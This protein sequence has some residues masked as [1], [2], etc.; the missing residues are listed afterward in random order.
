MQTNPSDIKNLILDFGGVIYEI[1][2]QKQMETFAELGIRNFD[3]LYSQARQSPLFADLECGRLDH[4]KFRNEV[5]RFIGRNIS[6]AEIDKAWNSILVGFP[7]ENVRFLEKLGKRY[8]LFL[9]SNTNAIHYDIY[10]REFYENYGYDFNRLFTKVFWSFKVGMRKPE[11]DIYEHVKKH[12]GAHDNCNC[13][14]IDDTQTNISAAENSGIPSLWLKPGM[15]LKDLF[16]ENL[17]L[18]ITG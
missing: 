3:E 1:S 14:F 17:D 7:E 4:G 5:G 9:L 2:H 15:K 12:V 16:D 6:E 18:K 10:I 11:P 8:E 13:L